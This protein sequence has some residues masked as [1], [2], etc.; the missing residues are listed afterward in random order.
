LLQKA[1]GKLEPLASLRRTFYEA[2]VTDMSTDER[3]HPPASGGDT[4][5]NCHMF[6]QAS[7][8]YRSDFRS[9]LADPGNYFLLSIFA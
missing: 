6:A 2:E 1:K 4:I 9:V 7:A 8:C 3:V 5:L